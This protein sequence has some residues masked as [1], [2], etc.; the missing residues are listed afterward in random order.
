MFGA[1][2][3]HAPW[4][5][6]VASSGKQWQAVA[7]SGKQWQAVASSGKQWQAVC[8]SMFFAWKEVRMTQFFRVHSCTSFAC[9]G[10]VTLT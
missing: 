7:S 6:A 3:S 1:L 4:Q 8:F 2:D 10:F 5:Q 9:T